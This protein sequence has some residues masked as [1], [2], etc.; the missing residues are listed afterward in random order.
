MNPVTVKDLVRE[1][2]KQ[3]DAGNGNKVVMI[4]NDTRFGAYNPVFELFED[5]ADVVK[6]K[7]NTSNPKAYIMLG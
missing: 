7:I 6:E 1:C 3:M 5:N 4:K 2:L